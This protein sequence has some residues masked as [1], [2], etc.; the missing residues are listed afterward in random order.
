MFTQ[1]EL[2]LAARGLAEHW[3]HTIL[4]S[5][6]VVIAPYVWPFVAPMIPAY[7]GGLA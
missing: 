4:V 7:L 5:T 1:L 2:Q 6:L 3:T